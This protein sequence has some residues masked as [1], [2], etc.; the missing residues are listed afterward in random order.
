MFIPPKIKTPLTS[1]KGVRALTDNLNCQGRIVSY[2]RCHLDFTGIP[3]ALQDTYISPASNACRCVADTLWLPHLTA[4]S[5]GH[6]MT[7]VSP[8]SQQRGLSVEAWSPL[9]PLQRFFAMNLV[10]LYDRAEIMSILNFRLK[11]LLSRCKQFIR[12]CKTVRNDFFR[13]RAGSVAQRSCIRVKT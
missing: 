13:T 5:A 4:P 2:P 9:L 11:R 6:L 1:V 8:D 7:C 3:C 12:R 10:I